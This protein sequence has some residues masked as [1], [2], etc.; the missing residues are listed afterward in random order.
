MS[1]VSKNQVSLT[2]HINTIHKSNENKCDSCGQ[3]FENR[4]TLIEHTV[5]NHRG[6]R[7]QGNRRSGFL[8]TDDCKRVFLRISSWRLPSL[9][10]T[11]KWTYKGQKKVC[12]HVFV[13]HVGYH[14]FVNHVRYHVYMNH[15]MLHNCI[16]GNS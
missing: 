8:T 16:L 9:I 6:G 11:D 4:E 2:H 12:Y 10:Q 5:H 13:N 1:Y 15:T 7:I 3:E 14:V